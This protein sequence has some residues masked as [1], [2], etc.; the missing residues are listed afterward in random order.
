MSLFEWI[1]VGLLG[2]WF[3]KYVMGGGFGLLADLTLGIL[4]GFFWGWFLGMFGIPH[5]TGPVGALILTFDGAVI[6][7]WLTRLIKKEGLVKSKAR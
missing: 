6:L 2:G 4:G 3:A 5:I 1:A 7:V